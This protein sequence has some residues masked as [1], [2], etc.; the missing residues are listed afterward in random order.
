MFQS[1]LI[2]RDF[3]GTCLPPPWHSELSDFVA[4]LFLVLK[5]HTEVYNLTFS[6][7][8]L[9][10]L[11]S[12]PGSGE[13]PRHGTRA[14]AVQRAGAADARGERQQAARPWGVCWCVWLVWLVCAL[15]LG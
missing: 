12:S 15:S 2:H 14:G 3:W 8:T 7:P 10:S 6:K 13:R 1:R 4:K 11:S 9:L 5:L